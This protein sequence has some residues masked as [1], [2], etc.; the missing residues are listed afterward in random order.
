MNKINGPSTFPLF[1][2]LMIIL[3]VSLCSYLYTAFSHTFFT[4]TNKLCGANWSAKTSP[5]AMAVVTYSR[6]VQRN[7]IKGLATY[8]ILQVRTSCIHKNPPMLHM[9]T[10]PL[11]WM[12]ICIQKPLLWMCIK[13]LF[14]PLLQ[15]CICVFNPPLL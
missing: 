15:H 14:K 1:V 8:N 4:L 11:L 13:T 9:H 12:C 2:L 7:L 3:A 10:K 6:A 5:S